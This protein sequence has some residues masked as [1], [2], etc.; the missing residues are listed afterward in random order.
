MLTFWKK[1]FLIY[2]PEDEDRCLSLKA[3][4]KHEK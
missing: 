4:Q 2:E 1:S 3:L